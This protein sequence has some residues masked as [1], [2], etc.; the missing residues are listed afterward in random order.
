MFAGAN[1]LA[2]VPQ[3]EADRLGR[4]LTAVGGIKAG[5]ADGSIP[6]YEGGLTK[7]P[8][9]YTPGSHLVDP[10][11]GDKPVATITAQNAG[12]YAARLTAGQQ[13]MLKL[14]PKLQDAGLSDPALLLSAGT[15]L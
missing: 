10:F 14:Y 2:K 15:G 13:A 8:A 5:N 12:Q 7:P 3:A 4:D 9:G 11:A 1:A 6:A